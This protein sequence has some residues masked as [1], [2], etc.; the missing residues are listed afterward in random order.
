VTLLLTEIHWLD[1]FS[2]SFILF[3]ADRQISK[4][5]GDYDSLRKK[6]FQIPYLQAGI[7]YFG[8]AYVPKKGSAEPEPMSDWLLR[9]IRKN[10]SLTNMELF[11]NELA[12]NLNSDIPPE[13]RRNYISGFHLSGYNSDGIPEFWFIRNVK[14]DRKTTTGIYEA[15]EDFLSC[16]ARA[17]GYDGQNPH[18]IKMGGQIYRNGHIRAHHVAGEKIDVFF[19]LLKEP[20]FKKVNTVTDYEAWVKFKLEVIA[21]FYKKYCRQSII[22]GRIDTFYILAKPNQSTEMIQKPSSSSTNTMPTSASSIQKT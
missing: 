8:L 7:G 19:N 10:S 11:A 15:R 16:D 9:F 5:N 3:A 21:Y 22:G 13:W 17:S 1:N 20:Q 6:I 2:D 18:S 4:P 12:N 14:D